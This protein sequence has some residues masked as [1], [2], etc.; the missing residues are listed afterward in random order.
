M[1]FDFL[2][3][4]LIY[5]FTVGND[6]S[7]D[8][9]SIIDRLID[10]NR[11]KQLKDENSYHWSKLGLTNLPSSLFDRFSLVVCIFLKLKMK[12]E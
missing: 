7:K 11:I 10:Y 3:L 1:I 9:L 8:S 2:L 12:N 4:N 6:I 5:Y